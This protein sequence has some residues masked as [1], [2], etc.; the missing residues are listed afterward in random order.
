MSV[1]RRALFKLHN[2]VGVAAA[3]VVV[4]VAFTGVVL[5]FRG[6]FKPETPT[7]A[8]VASPLGLE[9]IVAAA[10]AAG[11]APATDVTMPGGPTSPYRVWVDDEAETLLFLDG[12]GEVVGQRPTAGGWLQWMFKLHTGEIIGMPGQGVA[13]ASGLS[14]IILAAS[15]LGMVWSRRRRRRGPERPG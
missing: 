5:T 10:E 3:A 11:G 6:A 1:S 8:P 9:A 14:L 2:A 15:G 7:V 13:V 12:N 4:L